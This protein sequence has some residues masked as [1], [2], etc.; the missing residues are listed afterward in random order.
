MSFWSK[1]FSLGNSAGGS[2][3]QVKPDLDT[4]PAPP[5]VGQA[6]SCE[7]SSRAAVQ[8]KVQPQQAGPGS[9][10]AHLS[11]KQ[12]ADISLFIESEVIRLASGTSRSARQ[13]AAEALGKIGN[14]RTVG[15]LVAALGDKSSLVSMAAVDALV[16]IGGPA[17]VD[18][19]NVAL[20]SGQGTAK[21]EFVCMIYVLWNLNAVSKALLV[22]TGC[23]AVICNSFCP[24]S[25]ARESA[26]AEFSRRRVSNWHGKKK[27]RQRKAQ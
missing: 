24:G 1:I 4:Q 20:D 19:L 8:V 18:A 15:P 16:K 17:V 5:R 13:A 12:A 2:A 7:P 25:R 22:I 23:I 14:P 9:Q 21:R 10:T 27:D 26:Y 3:G 11:Y 6:R